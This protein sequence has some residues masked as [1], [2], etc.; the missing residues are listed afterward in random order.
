MVVPEWYSVEILHNSNFFLS[1]FSRVYDE[2]I[3]NLG[4]VSS[5]ERKKP[6]FARVGGV[7]VQQYDKNP[8][9]R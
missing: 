2:K 4:P 1:I 8:V 7:G 3:I 5:Q 6:F 9:D